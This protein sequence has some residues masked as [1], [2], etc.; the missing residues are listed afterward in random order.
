MKIKNINIAALVLAISSTFSAHASTD[1]FGYARAGLHVSPDGQKGNGH[2]DYIR[3]EGAPNKYR[4]GNEDDWAELGVRHDLYE[5]GTE[6]AEIGF[7]LG[8]W[9]NP[10]TR[11]NSFTIMQA[12]GQ[13]YGILGSEKTSLWA[14]Q[15]YTR[16]IADDMLDF[17]YWDNSGRGFGLRDIEAGDVLI[18]FATVY[19]NVAYTDYQ[20]ES[21]TRRSAVVMPEFRVHGIDFLNGNLTLGV[22]YAV[23][24]DDTD[25]KEHVGEGNYDRDGYMFTVNHKSNIAGAYN[26]F[27]VQMNGG[28]GVGGW[29]DGEGEL[30]NLTTPGTSYRIMNHG[31]CT[32][33]ESWGCQYSLAYENIS[34]DDA[35]DDGKDWFAVGIRPKYSWN[36]YMQTEVEL[37]YQLVNSE[38]YDDSNSSWK[39]TLAQKFQL[40]TVPHIRFYATYAEAE[41][42]WQEVS[43]GKH[44]S[45][46][47]T[48]IDSWTF[49][50]QFEAWW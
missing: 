18:D 44:S 19:N 34:M 16:N 36:Q 26:I 1:F 28:I 27:T 10:E 13:M 7:M 15:R 21:K 46:E 45:E 31:F 11:S 25:I 9:H 20:D 42:N 30:L 6:R 29:H 47:N 8:T 14:G 3:A 37:G 41:T 43:F 40:G 33:N 32:I 39:A 50:V 48:A 49:G 2:P 12:W 4:L 23:V 22:N 5:E 35:N 38:R 24:V 17:K